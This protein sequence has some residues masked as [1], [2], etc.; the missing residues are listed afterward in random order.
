[1]S[2]KKNTEVQFP[3]NKVPKENYQLQLSAVLP[4]KL[5]PGHLWQCHDELFGWM[6]AQWSRGL[7]YYTDHIVNSPPVA[8]VMTSVLLYNSGFQQWNSKCI[9][10]LLFI[11]IILLSFMALQRLDAKSVAFLCLIFFAMPGSP[12]LILTQKR[13][14][15]WHIKCHPLPS[16][17]HIPLS[18]WIIESVLSSLL[19]FAISLCPLLSSS[20]I[21]QKSRTSESQTQSFIACL[22]WSQGHFVIFGTSTLKEQQQSCHGIYI[23]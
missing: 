12:L 7:L 19:T 1:M 2:C 15:K 20:Q 14:S 22:E 17:P 21:E 11:C 3:V 9:L 4:C 13:M 8:P 18:Y 10:G 5:S 6:W 16:P 23:M